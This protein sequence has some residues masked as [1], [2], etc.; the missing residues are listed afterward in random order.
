[1]KK[2]ITCMILLYC[3]LTMQPGYALEMDEVVD[4]MEPTTSCCNS[5]RKVV[6][7][8]IPFLEQVVHMLVVTD[9]TTN[10][11]AKDKLKKLAGAGTENKDKE[12][13]QEYGA[14]VDDLFNFLNCKGTK[15]DKEQLEPVL[16]KL[17]AWKE[18]V[19]DPYTSYLS[20]IQKVLLLMNEL[21]GKAKGQSQKAKIQFQ[22]KIINFQS[23]VIDFQRS[24]LGCSV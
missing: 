17:K 18:A 8:V 5:S 11:S 4:F 23:K 3:T 1:M 13:M 20:E 10:E 24:L 6:L 21:V 16:K 7:A 19:D 22:S 15:C 9:A 2:K 14:I 12:I